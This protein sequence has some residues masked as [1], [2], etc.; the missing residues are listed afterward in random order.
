MSHNGYGYT[1]NSGFTLDLDFID[2]TIDLCPDIILSAIAV[3]GAGFFFLIY[4]SVTM[5]GGRKRKKRDSKESTL[6]RPGDL[7]MI[8]VDQTAAVCHKGDIFQ[9]FILRGISK[10][11][12]RVD[13]SF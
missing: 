11:C 1:K 13:S 12:H 2:D 3:A 8:E 10:S 7:A 6:C 4:T 5:A 9:P